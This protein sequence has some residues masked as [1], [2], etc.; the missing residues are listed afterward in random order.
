MLVQSPTGTASL[1]IS[2]ESERSRLLRLAE[3]QTAAHWLLDRQFSEEMMLTLMFEFAQFSSQSIVKSRQRSDDWKC[4]RVVVSSS[5]VLT[6]QCPAVA[7][8]GVN[9]R[10]PIVSKFF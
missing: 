6:P 9:S 5:A 7:T 2:G 1:M 8:T 4:E 10:R 3:T